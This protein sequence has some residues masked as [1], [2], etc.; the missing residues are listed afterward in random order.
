MKS[1]RMSP[2]YIKGNLQSKRDPGET[3]IINFIPMNTTL[4]QCSLRRQYPVFTELAR[5]IRQ[6]GH[7][8]K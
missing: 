4:A 7:E 3:P 1:V 2:F 6:M 5:E 8:E